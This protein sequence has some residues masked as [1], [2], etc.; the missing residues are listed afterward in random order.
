LESDSHARIQG[1]DLLQVLLNLTINALQATDTPQRV[2]IAAHLQTKPLDIP[3]LEDRPGQRFIGRDTFQNQPPM[4][5]ISIQDGGGGIPEEILV[6]LFHEKLTTK[7]AGQGTG[8]GLSIVKRLLT[9]AG[10]GIHLRTCVGE[11][12]TFTVCIPV[13][14]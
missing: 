9:Q 8:L 5:T 13:A 12:S 3:L 1:T 2:T 14:Q 6:R 11:G 7:P 10:G 4:V